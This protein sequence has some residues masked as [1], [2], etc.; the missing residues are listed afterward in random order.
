M[1]QKY[2]IYSPTPRYPKPYNIYE[3]NFEHLESLF[4]RRIESTIKRMDNISFEFW[5]S[6]QL[7]LT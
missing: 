7:I 2:N 1:D 3:I 4:Q 6:K 5:T